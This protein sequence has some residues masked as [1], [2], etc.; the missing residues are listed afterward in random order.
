MLNLSLY[1]VY[2]SVAQ[3][4]PIWTYYNVGQVLFYGFAIFSAILGG[5][6]AKRFDRFTLLVSWIT[7]GIFATISLIAFQG[8]PFIAVSSALLGVSLGFGLPSSLAFMAECTAIEERGRV[9]GVIILSTFILGFIVLALMSIFGLDIAQSILLFAVLR[10]VSFVALLFD[11]CDGKKQKSVAVARLPSVAYKEYLFYLVPWVLFC[12]AAG[13]ASNLF[14]ETSDYA[15]AVDFGSSLR[16]VFIAASSVIAGFVADRVGRKQPVIFGLII[17]GVSFALIGFAM[18][19]TTVVIYLIASGVAWGSFF[20]IFLAI[21]AD[22][23]AEGSREKFYGLGYILPLAIL[24][25]LGAIP[26]V[27]TFSSFSASSFSQILSVILFV[28][29]VPL[30]RAKETLPSRKVD[31]RKMKEHLRKVGEAVHERPKGGRSKGA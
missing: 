13:L 12:V 4:D 26:G 5:L 16:Y 24:F 17:L 21:P 7:L 3:N 9:S 27:A 1:D 6:F 28:A 15:S 31:E 10:G 23:S 18:S 8:S 20:A 22:L 11:R 19:P 2:G 30:L 29:I 14:P 25:G